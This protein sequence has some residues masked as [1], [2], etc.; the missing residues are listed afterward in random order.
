MKK[1]VIVLE[2]FFMIA[3]PITAQTG[4]QTEGRSIMMSHLG[5]TDTDKGIIWGET[6]NKVFGIIYDGEGSGGDNRLHL[7]EF[8]DSSTTDI[9][10]YKANGN[11]GIGVSDPL[12]PMH[13]NGQILTE[14]G[15]IFMSNLG[16]TDTDQGILWGETTNNVF[17]IIYDGEGSGGDNRLHL[18]EFIDGST[19]DIMTY[20]ANGNVGIGT[21]DPQATLQ[22]DGKVNISDDGLTPRAG[23]LR[24]NATNSDFEGYDGSVWRSLTNKKVYTINIGAGEIM[25]DR[26]DNEDFNIQGSHGYSTFAS[27]FSIG[28][29]LFCPLILPVGSKIIEVTYNYLDTNPVDEI[30]FVLRRFNQAGNGQDDFY[31]VNSSGIT[32]AGFETKSIIEDHTITDDSYYTFIFTIRRTNNGGFDDQRI[33]GVK[34]KYE[35]P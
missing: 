5:D 11:V 2:L 16:G 27:N 23:D 19:T 13:V 9:M 6:I 10:T 14:N 35:L 4:L 24:F 32:P 29:I 20:K 7:R 21:S 30:S 25:I 31:A 17:G 26:E 3:I 8:I 34:V 1:I 22:V 18:R 12:A 28:G 33:Q 15:S